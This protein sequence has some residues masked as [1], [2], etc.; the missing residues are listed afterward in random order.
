[1][2]DKKLIPFAILGYVLAA[3]FELPV[4]GI[5]LLDA[6]FAIKA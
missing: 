3:F 5:A 2:I 4:M 6:V 1:M